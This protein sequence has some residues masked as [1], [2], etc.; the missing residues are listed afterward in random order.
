MTATDPHDPEQAGRIAPARPAAPKPRRSTR[1]LLRPV[2]FLPGLLEPALIWRPAISA[3]GLGPDRVLAPELPGQSPGDT[4]ETTRADLTDGAWLDALADE[5]GRRFGGEPPLVVGHSTGGMLAIALARRHPSRVGSLC[6]VNT[7]TKLPKVSP[8]RA[9]WHGLL[10]D[11]AGAAGYLALWQ[12]WLSSRMTFERGFLLGAAAPVPV[13]GSDAM[14]RHFTR[15]D[16]W[17]VR[18]TA[19]WV[20]ANDVSDDLARVPHPILALIGRRDPVVPPEHQFGILARAP[21]AHARL[22]EGGHVLYLEAPR[23]VERALAAWR[24]LD[25]G[26]ASLPAA[27]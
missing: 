22:I 4:P 3:L 27:G 6:L 21:N 17:A 15:V 25:G 13:P 10:A 20:A 19:R 8:M 26:G 16:P 23:T 11:G 24:A 2:V 9:T 7:L 14:R 5:I 18:E 12:L 1:S